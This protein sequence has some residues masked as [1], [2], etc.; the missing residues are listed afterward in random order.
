MILLH[1]TYHYDQPEGDLGIPDASQTQAFL[2][3]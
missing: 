2:F 1:D 3:L